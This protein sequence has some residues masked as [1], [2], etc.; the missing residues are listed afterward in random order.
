[1]NIQNIIRGDSQLFIP[2]VTANNI[3][4]NLTG[5]TVFFTVNASNNPTDDSAAILKKQTTP[6]G[7]TAVLFNGVTYTID[8]TKGQAAIQLANSD[9]QNLV[10]GGYYFDI[11]VVDTSGNVVSLRQGNF[12]IIAD[13]TRRIV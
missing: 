9:T 8:P 10:P 12:T 1:M 4:L 11:Q 13:I 3:P 5:F 7:V 2:T 6:S